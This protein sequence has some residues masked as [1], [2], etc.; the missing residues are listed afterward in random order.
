MILA[1]VGPTASGKSARALALAEQSGAELISCDSMQ[2][3]RGADIGT[4][5][6]TSDERAR[7]P[8]HLIDVVEPDAE[9]SAMRYVELADQAIAAI[10]SRGRP[11]I[12]VGGTGL[13][14][15]ALRWGLFEAPPRDCTLR[16]RLTEE[17]KS[18]PG[19]LHAKL[20]ALD[21]ETARRVGPRDL[22]RIVR[23]LEVH[24]LTGAPISEHHAAHDPSERHPMRVLVLDPGKQILDERIATRARAMLEGG[25]LDEARRLRDRFGP[26]AAPLAA[27]GY[28][29]ALLHLDGKLSAEQLLPSI[30]SATRRY[31]RRQRTWFRKEPDVRFVTDA[32]DIAVD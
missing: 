26:R 16:E 3:Y 6:P 17:E 19:A 22:V 31:A 18:Q 9:F 30:I 15:R 24:A 21:P 27:V 7:V 25:L 29:E 10:Q 2:V 32:S 12:V 20:A 13:Y 1:I 4:A 5:K 11:V 8:H 28:K 14:L 23:A